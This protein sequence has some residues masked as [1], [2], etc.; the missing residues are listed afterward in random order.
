MTFRESIYERNIKGRE[1]T[2]HDSHRGLL[3]TCAPVLNLKITKY[4]ENALISWL[5]V[6]V[7]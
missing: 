4:V 6:L 5:N 3:F 7:Q 2:E 1:H